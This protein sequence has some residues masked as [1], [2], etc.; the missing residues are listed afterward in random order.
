MKIDVTN[1]EKKKFEIE[2]TDPVGCLVHP[3]GGEL[4][5]QC[6]H[7]H[8]PPRFPECIITCLKKNAHVVYPFS[9]YGTR[10]KVFTTKSEE[11]GLIEV[12]PVTKVLPSNP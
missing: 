1:K 11:R 4:L 7:K 10:M 2:F 12:L 8:Y 3:E 5:S 6:F 9:E